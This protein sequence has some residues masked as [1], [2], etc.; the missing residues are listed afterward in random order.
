MVREEHSRI[1][2]VIGTKAELI[3][4]M[5]IMRELQKRKLDYWFIHTGQ[6][7]LRD[8]CEELKVKKPDFILSREPPVNVGT[9]FWSKIKLSTFLW[10]IKTMFDIRKVVKRINPRYVI[11]H[12]D[13]MN[14]AMAAGASSTILNPFKKWKNVHLEAGLRSGSLKEPLPEE[15]T[16]QV[17]DRFSDLL[18]AVSE[19]STR[20]LKKE[21]SFVGGKIKHM[22][23]TIIDSAIITH[24]E[25]KKKKYSFPKGKFVLINLHRH[26]NIVD[27]KRMNAIVEILKTVKIKGVWPIHES[28]K[29]FL[30]D[31]NLWEEVKKIKNIKITPLVGYK[32]F[33]YL[34][35]KSYYLITDGGSIQE[36]SLVFKKPCVILR[37]NTERQEGLSTGINF[38]VGV[39]VNLA[40]KI[41]KS[42]EDNTIKVKKFDNPYGR[43]GISKK[44]INELLKI[45]ND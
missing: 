39:D 14:T 12:G 24:K 25:A 15:F 7:A 28:T 10:N 16:R 2:I 38:L 23:N 11:Y 21:F 13:T 20:N 35:S 29:K 30:K 34:L 6:H 45:K 42:I 26:E 3:K 36:E 43:V 33:I 5:P 31:Y 9:K 19:R 41:I 37:K 1:A 40:K 17:V 4:C 22:G 8:S 18:F 32:E 44:I 27:I